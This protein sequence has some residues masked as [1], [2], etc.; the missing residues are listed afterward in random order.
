M[1]NF[2]YIFF[3]IVSSSIFAQTNIEQDELFLKY[4]QEYL[5]SS[6]AQLG[7]NYERAINNFQSRFIDF[8]S[9]DKFEKAKDKERWLSKNISKTTFGSENEASEVYKNLVNSKNALDNN[10]KIVQDIRNE[11]LKKYD[12][13]LIWDVLQTRIKSKR[14]E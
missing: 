7:V 4:E 8:K 9:R 2:I 10:S 1:R 14:E 5:N 3:L 13:K 12:E 6:R 11:L